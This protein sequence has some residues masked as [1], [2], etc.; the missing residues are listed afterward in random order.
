MNV[1]LWSKHEAVRFSFPQPDVRTLGSCFTRAFVV[2][3]PHQQLDSVFSASKGL[4]R[5][6][7]HPKHGDTV[8]QTE[9]KDH[10]GEV[11]KTCVAYA[12]PACSQD[13]SMELHSLFSYLINFNLILVSFLPSFPWFSL[14]NF[15]SAP[16]SLG[17]ITFFLILWGLMT[18]SLPWIS[19]DI[20]YF[21]FVILKIKK[22]FW[23]MD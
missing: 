16:L 7:T 11:S 10:R 18:K 1:Y 3:T 20:S 17:S 23:E 13:V 8:P 5:E 12:M 21:K 4:A 2:L 6:K 15:C 14:R 22:R 9:G 19:T